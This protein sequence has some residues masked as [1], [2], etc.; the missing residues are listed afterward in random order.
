MHEDSP[1]RYPMLHY[2]LTLADYLHAARHY[3]R[4][5]SAQLLAFYF[6]LFVGT[7]FAAGADGASWLTVTGFGL[8]ICAAIAV[9]SWTGQYLRVRHQYRISPLIRQD[10]TIVCGPLGLRIVTDSSDLTIRWNELDAA[11]ES[12]KAFTFLTAAYHGLIIP[13]IMADERELR[14]MLRRHLPPRKL[15][16]LS[17]K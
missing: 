7:A 1:I 10:Q 16:L 17:L 6:A 13:K 9:L 11:I 5:R 2:R 12:P 14:A 8:L 3:N 4:K 15:K